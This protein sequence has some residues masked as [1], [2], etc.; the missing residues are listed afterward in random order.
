MTSNYMLASQRM[1]NF[2]VDMTIHW[3]LCDLWRCGIS[4]GPWLYNKTD[5]QDR[6]FCKEKLYK[7]IDPLRPQAINMINLYDI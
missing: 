7:L 6:S 4:F 2:L 5:Q 3:S 1:V